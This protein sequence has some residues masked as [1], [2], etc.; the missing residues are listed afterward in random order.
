M[1]CVEIAL[2][3]AAFASGGRIK[4]DGKYYMLIIS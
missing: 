2:C 1:R 4:I 3:F